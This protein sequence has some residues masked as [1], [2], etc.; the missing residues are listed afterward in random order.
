MATHDGSNQSIFNNSETLVEP[1]NLSKNGAIDNPDKDHMEEDTQIKWIEVTRNTRRY[2]ATINC[3][4]VP[5]TD[6]K[7]KINNLLKVLG[8]K[9]GFLECR[10]F[11]GKGEIW[12]NATFESDETMKQNCNVYLFE[13]NEFTLQPLKN[14]NDDDT[15]KRTLYIRD[16]PLDVNKSLLKVILE[17][18]FGE[19]ESLKTRLAGPWYRAEATFTENK[20]IQQNLSLWSI[21]YKKDLCRIVPAY[22]SRDDIEERNSRTAKLTGLPFGTTPIDLKEIL[23]KFKAKTCFIPRTRSRYHRCRFAY[24][25]FENDDDLLEAT[26]NTAIR[27]GEDELYWDSEDTKTCHKCGSSQHLVADCEER[28]SANSF[29]EKRK[30]FSTI[31]SRYRVPNYRKF[32]KTSYNNNNNKSDTY[33]KTNNKETQIQNSLETILKSFK[34]E[35]ND[36]FIAI[37]DQLIEINN[38]IKLLEIK[39]GLTKASPFNKASQ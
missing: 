5:G 2:K 7:E 35:L 33:Q 39:T 10:P 24:I 31:Y 18:K 17:E 37:N 1:I 15:K 25:S 11:F 8:T 19:I 36:K 13:E 6:L 22:F 21:Q 9:K 26:T 30:Q 20:G 38:R 23:E 34:D 4:H 3:I 28:E 29:R 16:L 12:L 27:F 14:R 32:S